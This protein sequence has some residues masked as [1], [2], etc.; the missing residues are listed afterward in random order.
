M[1]LARKD[2]NPLTTESY[3]RQK[4]GKIDDRGCNMKQ[5]YKTHEVKIIFTP[6]VKINFYV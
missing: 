4:N 1:T 3:D 5:S 6:G 2:K